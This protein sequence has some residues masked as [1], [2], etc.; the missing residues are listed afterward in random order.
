MKYTVGK[1]LFIMEKNVEVLREVLNLLE[2]EKKKFND[3]V[4]QNDFRIE[5]IN[6]YLREITKSETDDFKV[7][8]PR[9]SENKHREQ[10]EADAA[11]KEKIEKENAEYKKKIEYLRLLSD[12]VNIV[13]DNLESKEIDTEKQMEDSSSELE[14]IAIDNENTEVQKIRNQFNLEKKH[15]AHQIMNCISFITP[16]EE[17]AKIELSEIAKKMLE[18]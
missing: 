15:I 14:K 12:K 5:E 16:D 11:E 18:Y 9:N 4:N 10:I 3:L 6:S 2:E 13:M 17:R 8:S 1:G 7:F